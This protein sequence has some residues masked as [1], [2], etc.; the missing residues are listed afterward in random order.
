M[1]DGRPS[2]NALQNYG[3]APAPVIYHVFDATVLAGRNVMREL[4]EKPRALLEQ[5]ILPELSEP[6][7]TGARSMPPSSWL[8]QSVKEQGFE[9]PDA[10]RRNSVYEPGLRTGAWMKMRVN[11]GQEFVIGRLHARNKTFDAL[12]FGTSRRE[13]DRR[14]ENPQRVYTGH[15][16][17]A[18][19]KV[20]R[21]RDQRVPL[22]R[23]CRRRGAVG[24]AGS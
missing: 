21:A 23:I 18:V 24:G 15:P 14:G 13:V 7:G 22:L 16:R 5:E 20:Q 1:D 11:R 10:K 9:G 4:L 8:V 3:S 17:A 6:A 2:F 12:I 19:Q